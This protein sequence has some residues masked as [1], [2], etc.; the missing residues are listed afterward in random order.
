MSL[1]FHKGY[2]DNSSLITVNLFQRGDLN[3][4]TGIVLSYS[5]VIKYFLFWIMKTISLIL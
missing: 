5:M 1:Y 3:I 4:S 2:I